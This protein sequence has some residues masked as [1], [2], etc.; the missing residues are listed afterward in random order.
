MAAWMA[1]HD[2]DECCIFVALLVVFDRELKDLSWVSGSIGYGCSKAGV[3]AFTLPRRSFLDIRSRA[4]WHRCLASSPGL[5]GW[6]GLAVHLYLYIEG[7]DD[8][9]YI[10]NSLKRLLRPLF[11]PFVSR[12]QIT[13]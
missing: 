12:T 5:A 9:F 10:V 4:S 8:E 2:T 7:N 11:V 1:R 6:H 3:F 13:S